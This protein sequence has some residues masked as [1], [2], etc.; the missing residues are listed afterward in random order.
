M[1]V[2]ACGRRVSVVDVRVVCACAREER[3]F[4]WLG[5]LNIINYARFTPVWRRAA[6]LLAT[7]RRRGYGRRGCGWHGA[8]AG[9][10]GSGGWLGSG[11]DPPIPH[12][13]RS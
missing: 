9:G 11:L 10:A 13:T 1:C 4:V 6:W 2:R 8:G 3:L 7:R 5:V 12:D